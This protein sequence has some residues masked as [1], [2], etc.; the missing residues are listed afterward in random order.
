MSEIRVSGNRIH[1]RVD[2]NN[3]IEV[4]VQ[5]PAQSDAPEK[6]NAGVRCLLEPGGARLFAV[7]LVEAAKDAE[8]RR[9]KGNNG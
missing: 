2:Y 7:A 8:E 4:T 3:K 6:F 9:A 5:D 1:L